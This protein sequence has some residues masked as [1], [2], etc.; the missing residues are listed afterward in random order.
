MGLY[1]RRAC[2]ILVPGHGTIKIVPQ[3]GRNVSVTAPLSLE[4]VDKRGKRLADRR[5]R[6][7]KGK[8]KA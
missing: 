8:R 5:K 7:D 4:I 6:L 1:I 2:L 3:G